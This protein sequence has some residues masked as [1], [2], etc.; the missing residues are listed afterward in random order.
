MKITANTKKI[1]IQAL[2]SSRADFVLLLEQLIQKIKEGKDSFGSEYG[3][4]ME[5]DD[6]YVALDY[7]FTSNLDM[8]GKSKDLDCLTNPPKE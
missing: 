7:L 1:S 2:G 8:T 3:P 4:N 5:A 6:S